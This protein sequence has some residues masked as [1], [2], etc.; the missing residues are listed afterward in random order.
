[1]APRQQWQTIDNRKRKYTIDIKDDNFFYLAGLFNTFKIEGE[2]ALRF[3]II[4]APANDFMKP[5]HH[6]MPLIVPKHNIAD[7][8]NTSPIDIER[9][10]HL[11]GEL[12][13][14]AV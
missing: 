6:R 2:Q 3:V 9:I 5:I 11:A 4:T 14:K 7:W 8:L 1:M 12:E 13:A 10:Y